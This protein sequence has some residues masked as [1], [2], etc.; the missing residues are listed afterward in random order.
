[1]IGKLEKTILNIKAPGPNNP[2]TYVLTHFRFNTFLGL[3]F[4]IFKQNSNL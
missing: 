1:M 3:I 2:E 4:N